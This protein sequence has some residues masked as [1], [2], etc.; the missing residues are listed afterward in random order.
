MDDPEITEDAHAEFDDVI[1]APD[2]VHD[3]RS[4]D[5]AQNHYLGESLMSVGHRMSIRE[6]YGTPPTYHE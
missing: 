6:S 2:A 5:L 1:D 3:S 4:G